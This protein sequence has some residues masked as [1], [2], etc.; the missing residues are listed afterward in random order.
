MSNRDKTKEQKANDLRQSEHDISD[1]KNVED[2]QKM[3]EEALHFERDL[4]NDLANALPS[5]IYRIRVFRDVSLIEDNWLRSNDAPY[6]VEFANDRFFE[7]LHFDRL[8]YEKNPC[9]LH[10]FIYEADK[11][12]FARIN[13]ESNLHTT[14]FKWEGR[15][16]IENNI[17]WL[18]FKSIPRKMENGDVIWT[19]TLEDITE[20]KQTE[21]QITLK[22]IEL[23]KLN[24]DKDYF[25]SILAHDLKSPFNSILGF[26]DLLI[27][28]LREFNI[29]EIER[30]LTIVNHSAQSVYNLLEDILLWALSQSGKL[31][32]KPREFNFKRSCDA[33]IEIV[34]PNADSKNITI[35]TFDAENINVF[36]DSNMLNTILRNLLTNAIKFTN[37]GGTIN[38]YAQQNTAS[39]TISVSDNGIGIPPKILLNLF[40]ITQ[41][42]STNGTAN[43]KG[44][45]LGILLCKEFVE[46]HGGKI[47]VES[48][49][50][51]GTVFYFMLPMFA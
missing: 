14:P 31:P 45:G 5:G 17:I 30:Q 20:R 7:I 43:E 10:D 34:K 39:V 49:L 37:N 25:M 16:L 15:F 27:N 19:G 11:A 32:Y 18:H 8:T 26:L 46:K 44:T 36:A 29:N 12:E 48:E 47:W 28:N 42:Y 1:F 13:V 4:Y 24:A 6:S 41:V 2:I 22:N 38:I 35:N 9:T 50:G 21:E 3:N 51:K 23:L 33:V 40:D